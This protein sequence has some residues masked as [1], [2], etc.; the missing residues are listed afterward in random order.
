MKYQLMLK[1]LIKTQ[2]HDSY[3]LLYITSDTD[4]A[5]I[6][7]IIMISIQFPF[8]FL[9]NKLFD[10]CFVYIINYTSYPYPNQCQNVC[11]EKD[12]TILDATYTISLF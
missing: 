8:S 12:V 7:L 6:F 3:N 1:Q 10:Y 9:H 4:D 5:T 11:I 2:N